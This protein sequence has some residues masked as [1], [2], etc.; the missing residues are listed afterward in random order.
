[1]L[2]G[3]LFNNSKRQEKEMKQMFNTAELATIRMPLSPNDSYGVRLASDSNLVAQW[4]NSRAQHLFGR[5]GDSGFNYN[6]LWRVQKI[7]C[8]DLPLVFKESSSNAQES[9]REAL[10]EEISKQVD[11]YYNESPVYAEEHGVLVVHN[12][13]TISQRNII[14]RRRSV[15]KRYL[16]GAIE[17]YSPPLNINQSNSET[18]FILGLS[19]YLGKVGRKKNITSI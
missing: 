3:L 6:S 17:L 8:V 4:F 12:Y 11:N 19:G 10:F 16:Q 2:E 13:G 14:L 7:M 15:L 1:M 9:I 5:E 18:I